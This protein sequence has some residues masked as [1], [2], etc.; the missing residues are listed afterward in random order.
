[1]DYDTSHLDYELE[2]FSK[3]VMALHNND[4]ALLTELA[5]KATPMMLQAMVDVGE[6]MKRIAWSE[7]EN[8]GISLATAFKTFFLVPKKK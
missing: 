2:D 8:R 5:W 1:M 4:L 6:S 7:A 3:I